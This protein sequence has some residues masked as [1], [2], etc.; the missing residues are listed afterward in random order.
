MATTMIPA[1]PPRSVVFDLPDPEEK[2]RNFHGEVGGSVTWK[3]SVPT[4]YP[5]F[6]VIFDG[7]NPFDG[8]QDAEFKGTSLLV[9]SLKTAGKFHYAIKQ[10]KRDGTHKITRTYTMCIV[11]YG[12]FIHCVGCP[13]G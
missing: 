7:S 5:N 11:E 13:P 6:V 2:R 8:S 3:S 4:N 1:T 9:L 10:I 12:A